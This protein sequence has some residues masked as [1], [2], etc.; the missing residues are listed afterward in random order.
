MGLWDQVQD[1][2]DVEDRRSSPLV[3]LGAFGI[4]GTVVAITI[5]L[6]SGNVDPN[7]ITQLINQVTSS[8]AQSVNTNDGYA[9]FASQIL[10]SLNTY[11][12][13]ELTTVRT[14]YSAPKL[15]LFRQATQSACGGATSDVGPHYCPPDRTVYLDETFFAELTS[16]FG[17]QS[18]DVTQ[19]YVISHEVGHHVQN[20]LGTI[21]NLDTG[22]NQTSVKV[23]LQADCYSGM[24]MRSVAN[25]GII[26]PSEFEQ[27]I[28]AASA[29]GDDRIQKSTTGSIHPETWT[30]GSSQERVSWLQTGYNATSL[31]SCNTFR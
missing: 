30:H 8:S 31:E 18:G 20:I 5:S 11:W 22:D 2:G 28:S 29:V 6:L 15:V 23:E 25:Q 12:K 1:R 21:N 9:I 13:Q 3:P 26:Q 17:A 24:W 16:R 4:I 7:Q 14:S 27:A 19:A 10:G